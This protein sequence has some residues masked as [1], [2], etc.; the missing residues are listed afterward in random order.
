MASNFEL[1]LKKLDRFVRR[2]YTNRL[3]KGIIFFVA[4]FT[5]FFIGVTTLEHFGRFGT[6][7][8][9]FL[10]FS[11]WLGNGYILVRYVVIPLTR[12]YKLGKV[13]SAEQAAELIGQHFPQVKD[14]LTNTL[15]LQKLV[16]LSDTNRLL[17]EA[18]IDQR[19]EELKP[20]AFYKA[21]DLSQNKKYLKFAAVPLGAL[22]ILVFASP[23]VITDSTERILE[24]DETFEK[25][26]PFDFILQNE[27]LSFLK[28][29]DAEIVVRTE[30]EEIPAECYFE[31]KGNRYKMNRQEIGVFSYT[32]R[33]L[34]ESNSFNLSA[35]GYES[36][37]YELHVMPRPVFRSISLDVKYPEYIGREAE[38]LKDVTELFVPEGTQ[39][40]W[41]FETRHTGTIQV[42]TTDSLVE[43]NRKGEDIYS[44]SRIA[45]NLETLTFF[46][47]N[48][49]VSLHDSLKVHVKVI[50]DQYPKI[51]VS[52]MSDSLAT[53]IFYFKG[54]IT[55]DY[56]FTRLWFKYRK[57]G[58]ENWKQEEILL[59]K[60]VNNHLFFHAWNLKNLELAM[61][62]QLEYYFEVW[63][64]DAIHSPK[65]ARTHS[66]FYR[67]PG[68]KEIREEADQKAE[69]IVKDLEASLKEAKD[70]KREID[71]LN[72]KLIEKKNISWEEKKQLNE[73]L[74]KQKNLRNS[75]E[76]IQK[77]NK[78]RN[79]R[80]R[81]F[82]QQDESLME[83]QRQLEELLEKVMDE[84]MKKML[85]EIQKMMDEMN[86]NQMQDKLD[87][88]ELS[89]KDLEKELDRSLELFKQLEF[90]DKLNKTIE[91][92]KELQKK[93]EELREKTADKNEESEDLKQEQDSLNKEMEDLE[94]ELEKLEEL[95]KDLENKQ[96]LPNVDQ[97]KKE[98][99]DQM[100]KASD[101]MQQQKKKE[102][103][104]SQQQAERQ[105]QKMQQKLSD[106]QQQMQEEQQ[107]E[108]IEALRRLRKNLLELSFD[109]ESL[110]DESK[111]TQPNDPRFTELTK[112]Q[113]RLKDNAKMIEDS[114]FALSK[115]NIQIQSVVNKEISAINSNL[116]KSIKHMADRKLPETL[117]RQQLVMTSVN[118]LALLLDESI[119]Q[120]QKQMAE[121]K[122][123]NKSCS[124]PGSGGM[125]KMGDLKKMQQQLSKQ[126]QKLAEQ[127]KQQQQN[128][129]KPG[130]G[131][132]KGQGNK[133]GRGS[134]M[135][136]QIAKMAAE[137]SAI[138]NE[139]R[140]L[141][142]QME[143]QNGGAG[144]KK[145][146]EL[147]E[148]NEEDLL[149]QQLTQE[150]IRRQEEIM[151][152]LL[153]SEKAEREREFDNKRESN[154][155]DNL[156]EEQQMLEK[157]K[158]EKEKQ[159]ELLESIPLNLKPFYKN[160]VN[161]YYNNL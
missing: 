128:G 86:K 160:K 88:M 11:F 30:G 76:E 68:K 50:K 158:Q 79:E 77:K 10:F 15:Q 152:R 59:P 19:A 149:N 119:Q 92:L 98:A 136:E 139:L 75:F 147:M 71:K 155:A 24:Y 78:E 28:D 74:E 80:Q 53:R 67:M 148:Q 7:I 45:S 38:T 47:S 109:Q 106:L 13:I 60:G 127:M 143:G 41:D 34:Q 110:I 56:G 70:I 129:K 150:S 17:I 124:K 36:N 137:Q 46:P 83:K 116:E 32:L 63:D 94:K 146:Q 117:S 105:M 111:K 73:L 33:N 159:L 16:E 104:K 112:E 52:K 35:N 5:L 8:R 18:S 62:D 81:E 43:V 156:Y 96:N 115:R 134:Q 140:R 37:S 65:S 27:N 84:E 130:S 151:S 161:E 29:Q 144:L 1:I 108:D 121:K 103:Q 12:L 138:R 133:S 118:N 85:E 58:G 49:E 131:Q 2:Y 66:L 114:L 142:E 54:Q 6:G 107:Q 99:K 123:G 39:L 69:E 26:K 89:N 14:K 42:K 23:S 113:K 87:K 90:E 101:Q 3:V 126:M 97:E 51:Q 22:L 102:A 141:S 82:S 21:I 55:D 135:S 57:N 153:E 154:T 48:S 40:T 44:F 157:Y 25:P 132:K 145:L 125:P 91:D 4:W 122:F 120:S 95:N 20:I 100:Q 9:T 31:W 61:E 93:Q 64:N 72:R